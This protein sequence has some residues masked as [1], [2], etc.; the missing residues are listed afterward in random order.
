MNQ[1]KINV[2]DEVR[3]KLEGLTTDQKKVLVRKF[4]IEV[5]GA[6]YQ[7]AVR[8][9]RWNGKTSFFTISG[10]TYV[11]LL[12]EIIP[13][14]QQWDCTFEVVDHRDYKCEF[15]FSTVTTDVFAH[16]VWPKGHPNEGQ[17]VIVRD[18]QI[19][20]VNRFFQNPQ[21]IQ[22]VATGSGKCLAGETS[23]VFEIDETTEFGKFL[24][25]KMGTKK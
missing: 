12:P 2:L 15:E 1:I 3:C 13:I 24:L 22:E 21:S 14:L 11:N 6:K 25:S 19:D 4:E 20:I 16:K 17:P 5:P 8:L 23:I 10:M 7:P 9:G 18:Y